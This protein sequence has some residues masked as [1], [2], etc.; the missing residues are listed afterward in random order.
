MR[1]IPLVLL[2][3]AT[4]ARAER[5][6]LRGATMGTTY[7]VKLVAAPAAVDIARLHADVEKLLAEIDRQMSTYRPDSELSRFNR[8]PAGEW[9]P[10]SA[11]T[12]EVAHR[13]RTYIP[14][15]WCIVR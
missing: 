9:F 2:I 8:A 3:I 12:A 15:V 1:I 14:R 13:A 6:V 11:A 5:F 7:H 4:S 10:V